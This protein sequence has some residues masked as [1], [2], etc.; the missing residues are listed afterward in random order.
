M[1]YC[2]PS[3]GLMTHAYF[4]TGLTG[5]I[6]NSDGDDHSITIPWLFQLNL[7]S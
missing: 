5:F 6:S 2:T 4:T 3:N 1:Y 7:V